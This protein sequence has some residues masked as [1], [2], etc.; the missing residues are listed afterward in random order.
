[1]F[2]LAGAGVLWRISKDAPDNNRNGDEEQKVTDH[3]I[4]PFA[5]QWGN[6]P[7][8][9]RRAVRGRPVMA[10]APSCEPLDHHSCTAPCPSQT[11]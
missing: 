11:R 7:N 9:P 4:L 5:D 8:T 3:G 10:N 2:H 6:K 1:M